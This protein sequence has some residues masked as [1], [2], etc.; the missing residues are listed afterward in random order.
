MGEVLPMLA[1]LGAS[2]YTDR[3]V[4]ETRAAGVTIVTAD[5]TGA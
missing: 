4:E 5:E 1:C 3:A 2:F